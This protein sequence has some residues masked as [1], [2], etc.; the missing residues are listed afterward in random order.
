MSIITIKTWLDSGAN[1]QSAYKTEFE[2][3]EA[4]WNALSEDEKDEYAKEHAWNRMDWG[5]VIKEKN[6]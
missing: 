3:D 4:D 2:I 5:W 6:T 1:H